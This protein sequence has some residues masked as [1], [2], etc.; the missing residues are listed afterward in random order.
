ME[1]DK[2]WVDSLKRGEPQ[3]I[4][5]IVTLYGH[6]LLRNAFLLCGNESD[7]HDLVQETFLQAIKSINKFEGKSTPHTWMYGILLNVFRQY[8]RKKRRLFF[9]GDIK[10]KESASS[11][12][13]EHHLDIKN[14][15]SKICDLIKTLSNNHREVLILRY[16]EGLNIA[17]IAEITRLPKGTVKS[18]LHYATMALRKKMPENLNL[19]HDSNTHKRK[20]TK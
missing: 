18:R 3:S 4:E 8:V 17:E 7:A 5:K 11:I 13:I 2:E 14:V 10:N 6:R 9:S 19:F 15:F 12:D 1:K 16:F 20:Q